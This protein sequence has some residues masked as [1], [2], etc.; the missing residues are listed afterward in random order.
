M[1][2]LVSLVMK[3][4]ASELLH[5]EAIKVDQ[6]M[7]DFLA[8]MALVPRIEGRRDDFTLRFLGLLKRRSEIAQRALGITNSHGAKRE[9]PPVPALRAG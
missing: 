1:S 2:D 9:P 7:E 3:A 4:A 8:E 5:Q 6:E